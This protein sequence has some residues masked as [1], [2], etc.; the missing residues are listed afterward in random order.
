MSPQ[1]VGDTANLRPAAPESGYTVPED[2]TR[3]C[4]RPATGTALFQE[5]ANSIIGRDL[6]N[7]ARR[8]RSRW[9]QLPDKLNGLAMAE[10][11]VSLPDSQDLRV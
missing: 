4:T 3:R 10:W 8:E 9:V 5:R 2:A 1:L 7:D 11:P 6:D